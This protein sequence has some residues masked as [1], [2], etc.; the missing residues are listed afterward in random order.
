[1]STISEILQFTVSTQSGAKSRTCYDTYLGTFLDEIKT[2][3][4]KIQIEKIREY[5][6]KGDEENKKR[7]KK[8][9]TC[10]TFCA[11]FDH[12]RRKSALK[13]YN[14]LMVLDIDHLSSDEFIRIWNVLQ[15]DPFVFS[16]W[17]SP[18][19]GIKG[20]ISMNF[21]IP[22]NTSNY[23]VI[24][25]Y[26]SYAFTIISEYFKEKYNI[27][28][29]SSGSDTTRLCFTSYD[30]NLV[31]KE[32][33]AI[34]EIQELP[35]LND[36]IKKSSSRSYNNVLKYIPKSQTYYNSDTFQNTQSKNSQRNRRRIKSIIKFLYKN[37][38]SITTTYNMWL[39]VAFA[40]ANSFTYDIGKIYF[41]S[42]SQIDSNYKQ[43]ECN[44]IL[45]DAYKYSSGEITFA[46]ILYY[47]KEVGYKINS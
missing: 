14:S 27:D 9:L 29:D 38:Q 44:K 18:S 20:L 24:S 11:S 45:E 17:T 2:G 13:K 42:I 15:S 10:I 28:L 7:H 36:E 21:S 30:P 12:V 39:E 5:D 41:H 40:I 26:H 33:F 23:S 34:Y 35:Y 16:F 4:Y 22:I 43:D 37:N 3:A 25:K 32:S 47:A 46:T 8:S 6:K 1:M 19:Y 31:I